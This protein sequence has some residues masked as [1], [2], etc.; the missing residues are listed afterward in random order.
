MMRRIYGRQPGDPVKDLDVN[1]AIWGQFM[2]ATLQVAVYLGQ[3]YDAN[4]RYAKNTIW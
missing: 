4:L 3:D 1:L 2:N